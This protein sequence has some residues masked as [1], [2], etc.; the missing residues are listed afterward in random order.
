MNMIGHQDVIADPPA[1]ESRG[2]IPN[3]AHDGVAFW[4]SE[5]RFSL[6]CTP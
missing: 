5:D 4:I 6:V 2:A 1:I 3:A